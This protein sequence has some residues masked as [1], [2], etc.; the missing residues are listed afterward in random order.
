LRSPTATSGFGNRAE[1]QAISGHQRPSEQRELRRSTL[2]VTPGNA[3][4]CVVADTSHGI[5]DE[6][7]HQ[8]NLRVDKF[9]LLHGAEN[10]STAPG[11]TPGLIFGI[12]EAHLQ[13]PEQSSKVRG[14]KELR[15]LVLQFPRGEGNA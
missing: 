4:D 12:S 7:H 10:C 6:R 11:L 9:C 3:A 2:L 15:A 5:F 8:K 14:S 1:T 13:S